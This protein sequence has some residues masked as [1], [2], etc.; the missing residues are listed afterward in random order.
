M[1]KVKWNVLVFPG[2]TENGLEIYKSLVN[3]KEVRLLSVASDVKNH[4]EYVYKNHYVIPSIYENNCIDELNKII[5]QNNINYLFP[6]NSL[7]IDFLIENRKYINC[8]ILL[9]NNE[10]V[11][12]TRNKEETYK[13]LKNIINIPKL[14]D[15]YNIDEF[16][17]FLK[18]K[19]GYGSQNNYIANSKEELKSIISKINIS[20]YI[21]SEYLPY[22]EYTVECFSNKKSILFVLARTRE[23]IRMGTS[24]H[25]EIANQ[26]VQMVAKNYASKI[27]ENIPIEGLWFFQLKRGKDNKLYLLEIDIRVAGTMALSR[28]LGVNLPL[29][30]IYYFSGFDIQ[31]NRQNYDLIIDRSLNNRYKIKFDYSVVYIDLDDT[32]IVKNRINTQIIKFLFQCINKNIKIVL[33]SKSL[34]KDKIAFLKKYKIYEIFD[35]MIWLKEDDCKADFI[36]EKDSIFIDDSFSQRKKVEEKLHIPT[37][38]PSMIEILLDDRSE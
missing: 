31:I 9:P 17:V 29:L 4:A 7:V 21:I 26:E 28:G 6:A 37:F 24:M 13:I 38:D 15:I 11:K 30:N 2:G 8:P 3:C 18:P 1:N 23:R 33:I 22:E 35:E 34:E 27:I 10:V 5:K 16:P 32:I 19:K 25:S 14:Y 36:K 12:I 20:D